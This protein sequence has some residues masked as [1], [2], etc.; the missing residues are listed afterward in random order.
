MDKKGIIQSLPQP[1]KSVADRRLRYIQ[2][3]RRERQVAMGI[4]RLKSEEKVH[5]NMIKLHFITITN[6]NTKSLEK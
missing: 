1:V 3:P 5:I 4:D 6:M 2:S